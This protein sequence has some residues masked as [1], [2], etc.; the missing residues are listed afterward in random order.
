M[1]KRLQKRKKRTVQLS[2]K[3]YNANEGLVLEVVKS[4]GIF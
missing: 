2:Q 1:R 4:C 3:Q